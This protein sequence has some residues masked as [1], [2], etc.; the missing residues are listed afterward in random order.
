M[1][2]R[3]TMDART[4]QI[5]FRGTVE[6]LDLAAPLLK[7]AGDTVLIQRGRP[8]MLVMRCPSGCGDN[9]IINLDNRTGYAWRFYQDRRG[10]TIY[11]SYWREDGCQS[12]FIVWND[13]I[14]W[15]YGWESDESDTW[16]VSH[17][18]EETVLAALPN[19]RFIKYDELAEQ[20][21]LIPWEALQACRQLVKQGK[22]ISGK[23][24]RSGEFRKK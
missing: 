7:I 18:I 6:N 22:A 24:K 10:L 15:C 23:G 14:Y 2:E 19:D 9:L 13:R 16:S 17:S 20:V 5:T 12:H 4:K 11:P 1:R 3:L 8:R 21:N